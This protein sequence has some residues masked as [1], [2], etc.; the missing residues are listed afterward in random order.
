M[1][2]GRAAAPRSPAGGCAAPRQRRCRAGRAEPCP[3]SAG[4]LAQLWQRQGR[5]RLPAPCPHPSWE[6]E[7]ESGEC[8]RA[9]GCNRYGRRGGLAAGGFRGSGRTGRTGCEKGG[10]GIL[11]L[12]SLFLRV[13]SESVLS[14]KKERWPG[15]GEIRVLL[16]ASPVGWAKAEQEGSGSEETPVVQKSQVGDTHTCGTVLV[17]P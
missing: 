7:T 15:R 16:E 3:G 9:K 13:T 4:R 10:S 1:V 6:L 12:V 8:R 2:H 5:P 14:T 11:H 17:S